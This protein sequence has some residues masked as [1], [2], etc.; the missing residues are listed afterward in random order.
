MIWYT[1]VLGNITLKLVNISVISRSYRC[2]CDESIKINSLET[3]K[4][5]P[6][7]FLTIVMMLYIRSSELTAFFFFWKTL[8]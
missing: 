2:V 8:F 5:T 4:Y 7:Y 6:E 3:L 1:H